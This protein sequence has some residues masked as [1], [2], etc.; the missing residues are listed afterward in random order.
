METHV[1]DHRRG[2]TG[3]QIFGFQIFASVVAFAG[4]FG[5]GACF[6]GVAALGLP[7]TGDAQCG[8]KD[9]C[10]NGFCGGV[11]ACSDGSTITEAAVCDGVLDCPDNT[12]E[13]YELC[14]GD[15]ESFTC[16]DETLI[17]KAL[18]CDGAA[19]CPDASDED[20]SMCAGAGVNQCGGSEGD[21]G[22]SLGPSQAGVPTSPDIAV[23]DFI[24]SMAE[25][26]IVASPGGDQVKLVSFD[27]EGASQAIFF[28]GPPPSFGTSTVVDF[29]LGRADDGGQLDLFVAT[30]GT[31]LPGA[32]AGIYVFVNN[33]PMPPTPF[34]AVVSL[35]GLLPAELVGME[36][37]K[38]DD[39]DANDIVVIADGTLANGRVFVAVGDRSAAEQG[40]PYFEFELQE[41]LVIGYDDFLDS[42]LIDI[43]ADG[44]DD[45]L[46]STVTDSKGVLWVVERSGTGGEGPV[47]WETPESIMLAF[48]GVELATGRFTTTMPADDFAILDIV[49]GRV[50]AIINMGGTLTPMQQVMLE[51]GQVSGLTL[52]DMNCD[53]R[54]DYVFNVASPAEVRV[55]LGDGMGGLASDD[56][57]T[58]ANSG[59]PRGGLAVTDYDGD[60]TPDIVSA[61]DA[62]E[63]V[64]MPEVRLLL[65]DAASGR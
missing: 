34:G 61:V 5:V 32:D 57:I 22:Y 16:A 48:P 1:S 60:A 27:E 58:H 45:L 53:G 44:D 19:D 9:S 6:D 24:N 29:E 63:G 54:A 7:C 52:A 25:D 49:T 14:F 50:Q 64:S 3:F 17:P 26:V 31:A 51:G 33:A 41:A 4:S 23:A 8:P 18:V 11:F 20:A 35:P 56:A 12:D 10:I 36:I 42:E 43:D 65:T 13:D 15:A 55:L 39:D 30:S 46:V 38:L 59:T 28:N 2:R 37:G 62:G 40:N 47:E 21:L